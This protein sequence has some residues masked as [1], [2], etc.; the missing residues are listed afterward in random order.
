MITR[1]KRL[2]V[3]DIIGNEV[4]QWQQ[5]EVITIEAGTGVG[6]SYFIKNTLYQKAK[7]EGTKILFILNRTRLSEQF[8]SEIEQDNKTDVIKI[9]LYQNVEDFVRKRS[10]VVSKD[11]Q[12]IVSDE[13]HYFLTESK[14][15]NNT[16]DSFNLIISESEKTRIFMSA[17]AD[18]AI[19]YFRFK[20]IEHRSYNVPHD[21]SHIKE[22]T[23]YR[24]D[25]VLEKFLHTIPKNQKAVC[26]SKSAK[27]ASTL[28]TIFKDSLFVCSASG[29]SREK[30]YLDKERISRMLM[31]EKFE[32]KFLFTT[33]TL[34]NGVNLKDKKIKYV[35]ADIED[36]D[37]LIQCLGRKRIVSDSDKVTVIIKNISDKMINKKLKDCERIINPAKYLMDHGSLEYVKK[38]RRYSSPVIYDT[39]T[40]DNEKVEKVINEL[41]YFK[42]CYDKKFYEEILQEENGYMKHLQTKLQQ[43][44]YTILDDTYEKATLSDYLDSIVGKQLYKEEQE[45]LIKKVNIRDSRSRLQRGCR[46]INEYFIENNFPYSVKDKMKNNKRKLDNN[47]PNPNYT[48]TYWSLA[49]HN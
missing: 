21:Y 49:K 24:N 18:A 48:K 12:Y 29:T 23:F 39:V 42:E 47:E 27:K 14:F 25:K 32:E 4:E 34:D 5:G 10:V 35:V 33:S 40:V 8:Q 46:I 20:H 30:K 7:R 28:H 1:K 22:L 9:L 3:T 13:F 15:N 37:T 41:R 2:T 6:K 19:E 26:F 11:Y 17:T 45:E 43:N 44:S 16:E 38:Y 31:E 36:I